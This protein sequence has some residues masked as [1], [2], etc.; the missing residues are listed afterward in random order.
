M[1]KAMN[2]SQISKVSAS[3]DKYM[4]KYVNSVKENHFYT[5]IKIELLQ[6][7]LNG[8]R[9]VIALRI[10]FSWILQIIQRLYFN[11]IIRVLFSQWIRY[12]MH[13]TLK[14]QQLKNPRAEKHSLTKL[15]FSNDA[16]VWMISIIL[17]HQTATSSL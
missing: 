12:R 1:C 3:E 4:Y 15:E 10:I 13:M 9:V 14:R 16:N 17:M 2:I 8:D 5:H 7:C 6:C 11:F